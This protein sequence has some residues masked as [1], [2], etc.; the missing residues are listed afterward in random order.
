[1]ARMP[2]WGIKFCKLEGVDFAA[3]AA[4][5]VRSLADQN[6]LSSRKGRTCKTMRRVV[7]TGVA[8]VLP[9]AGRFVADD[10]V[11]RRRRRCMSGTQALAPATKCLSRKPVVGTNTG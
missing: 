10:K 1:M 8:F 4:R 3:W 2:T 5:G 7:W 9:G 6:S 11:N